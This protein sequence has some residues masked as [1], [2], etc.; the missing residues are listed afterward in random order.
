[1]KQHFADKLRDI[2]NQ[3]SE[4]DEALIQKINSMFVRYAPKLKRRIPEDVQNDLVKAAKQKQHKKI[5]SIDDYLSSELKND[6][7]ITAND[8]LEDIKNFESIF[9]QAQSNSLIDYKEYDGARTLEYKIH[10]DRYMIY[11]RNQIFILSIVLGTDSLEKALQNEGFK[12]S[13]LNSKKL[14]VEW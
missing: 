7:A 4:N 5:I 14:H 1:M 8:C 2:A 3:T 9:A 6:K 11:N 10:D 12:V 13:V